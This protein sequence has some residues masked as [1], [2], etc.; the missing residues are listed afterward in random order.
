VTLFLPVVL[1]PLA[2]RGK[3]RMEKQVLVL[4]LRGL[5]GRR[6]KTWD[7]KDDRAVPPRRSSFNQ[8]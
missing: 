2:N 6:E 5:V 4:L 7:R 8:G 3:K 1:F